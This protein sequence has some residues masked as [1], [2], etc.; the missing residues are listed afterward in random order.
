MTVGSLRAWVMG[1]L[2]R[3]MRQLVTEGVAAL[4]GLA[5]A[6]HSGHNDGEDGS[7]FEPDTD[8]DV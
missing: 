6:A 1:A 8:L 2:L 4:G 3:H 7:V 5:E